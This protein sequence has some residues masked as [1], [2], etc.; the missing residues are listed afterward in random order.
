[1]EIR[2]KRKNIDNLLGT[3]QFCKPCTLL[4][5]RSIDN[6]AKI[7]DIFIQF[8]CCVLGNASRSARDIIAA[9]CSAALVLFVHFHG[10]IP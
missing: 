5:Y 7:V 8:C 1:M 4:A 2:G 9:V 6:F 10:Y 3:I